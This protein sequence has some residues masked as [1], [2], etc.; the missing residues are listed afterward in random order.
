MNNDDDDDRVINFKC[1][2]IN[3]QFQSNL[4]LHKIVFFLESMHVVSFLACICFFVYNGKT[5]VVSVMTF[6]LIFR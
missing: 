2:F 3:D 4:C 6:L 1:N 5:C